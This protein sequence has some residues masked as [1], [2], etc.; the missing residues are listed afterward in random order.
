MHTHFC[1]TAFILALCIL[2]VSCG[3]PPQTGKL[4]PIP[5]ANRS[6][7]AAAST[8]T[9]TRTASAT[10]ALPA[11]AAVDVTKKPL[12]KAFFR[13][14]HDVNRLEDLYGTTR[15][16]VQNLS[17]VSNCSLDVLKAFITTDWAPIILSRRSGKGHLT[18]VMGYDD[19]DQQIQV[20]NPLGAQRRGLQ[21]RAGRTLTY[22]EFEKEWT[23]GSR[24]ACVLITPKKLNEV[25]IHAALEKYLPKEQV[26]RVQVRSR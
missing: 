22:S 25:S 11:S 21:T 9:K 15:G 16:Q 4:P 12:L 8:P 1:H 18:T 13:G 3:P 10:G 20:G 6:Q 24:R 7:S 23:T 19:A 26:A 2:L 5:S 17:I 14:Q